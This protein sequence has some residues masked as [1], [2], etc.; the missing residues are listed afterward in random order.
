MRTPLQ[1]NDDH[2]FKLF[3]GLCTPTFEWYQ[4]VYTHSLGAVERHSGKCRESLTKGGKQ[5]RKWAH[6]VDDKSIAHHR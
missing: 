6:Q 4:Q 3:T 1:L 2:S 5:T